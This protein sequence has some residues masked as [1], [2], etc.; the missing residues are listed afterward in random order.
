MNCIQW[1]I[2]LIS[3][4]ASEEILLS[5]QQLLH[6]R[7]THIDTC[8][9]RNCQQYTDV[10]YKTFSKV[11]EVHLKHTEYDC[12]GSK[13]IFFPLSTLSQFSNCR[14]CISGSIKLL[15]V[16]K[17]MPTSYSQSHQKV[18][19]VISTKYKHQQIHFAN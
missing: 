14:L 3:L 17:V 18:F 19:A 2:H 8:T 11:G 6:E 9:L 12:L 7:K 1:A 5:S 4:F 15:L 10:L 16:V 13:K